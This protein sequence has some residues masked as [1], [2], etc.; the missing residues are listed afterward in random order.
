MGYNKAKTFAGTR[1]REAA[2]DCKVRK[3]L[4]ELKHTAS[5]TKVEQLA[6]RKYTNG[7]AILTL[8]VNVSILRFGKSI[9]LQCRKHNT[10]SLVVSR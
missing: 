6:Q 8:L 3:T 4:L 1:L 10:P 2:R 5:R 7:Q 9:N